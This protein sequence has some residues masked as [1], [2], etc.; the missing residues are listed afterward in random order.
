MKKY[1]LIFAVA[2]VALSVAMPAFADVEFLYGGQFRWRINSSDGNMSGTEEGGYYGNFQPQTITSVGKP[3][4]YWNANDN[5]FYIDQR[6][7]LYFTF[8]GSPNLKVVTKFEMGDTNLGRSRSCC[9]PGGY[10]DGAKRRWRDR[11]RQ[12][13]NRDQECVFRVQSPCVSHDHYYRYPDHQ[14]AGFLDIGRRLFSGCLHYQAGSLPYS[15]R[16]HR[17]PVRC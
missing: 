12:H 4:G 10:Q 9:F 8:Q 5:R 7:R 14:S 15:R 1:L 3:N 13:L 2:L 11:C 6:L 17:R 16:V